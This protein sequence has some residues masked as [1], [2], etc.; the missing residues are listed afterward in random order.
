MASLRFL[1]FILGP[2]V[3]VA[4]VFWPIVCLFSSVSWINSNRHTADSVRLS[5]LSCCVSRFLEKM[6]PV[7]R[8]HIYF[9]PLFTPITELLAARNKPADVHVN[10]SYHFLLL[11]LEAVAIRVRRGTS[12]WISGMSMVDFSLLLSKFLPVRPVRQRPE[13]NRPGEE[14]R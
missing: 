6:P 9:W 3:L 5:R 7:G 14:I 13:K 1:V 11:G 10:F 12:D 8:L 2:P 4:G